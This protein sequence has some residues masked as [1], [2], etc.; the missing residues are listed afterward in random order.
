LN[1]VEGFLIKQN[2]IENVFPEHLFEIS[3]K[4]PICRHPFTMAISKKT[5]WPVFVNHGIHKSFPIGVG[6][7]LKEWLLH[8]KQL[9]AKGDA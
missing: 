5:K 8:V 6:F 1:A 9:N 3:S 4:R 7:Y 2:K